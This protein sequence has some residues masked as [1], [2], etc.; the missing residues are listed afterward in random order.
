MLERPPA[1]EDPGCGYQNK[2]HLWVCWGHSSGSQGLGTC[3]SF[4]GNQTIMDA[5]FL[6]SSASKLHFPR[7]LRIMYVLS[8]PF[9][10]L[11]FQALLLGPV[12]IHSW[13]CLNDL[14]H[15]SS[16][17]D[18]KDFCLLHTGELSASFALLCSRIWRKA[19]GQPGR[20]PRRTTEIQRTSGT[21][22]TCSVP[23]EMTSVSSLI[24]AV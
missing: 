16:K 12:P 7:E 11:D 6:P 17:P 14:C 2:K 22:G 8:Q 3:P 24:S 18:S 15:G 5:P 20:A 19:G 21:S 4:Q 1:L 9:S 10:S 23:K 13:K